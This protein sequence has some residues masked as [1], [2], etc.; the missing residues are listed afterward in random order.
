MSRLRPTG[1]GGQARESRHGN[2]IG[3]FQPNT[4]AAKRSTITVSE[5]HNAASASNRGKD[6]TGIATPKTSATTAQ[7]ATPRTA[8]PFVTRPAYMKEAL[9]V[10]LGRFVYVCEPIEGRAS[11]ERRC[12]ERNRKTAKRAAQ[13]SA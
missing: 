9:T 3:I 11:G 4:G 2:S 6:L 10:A 12:P 7:N 1:Y 13:P 8:E 5:T